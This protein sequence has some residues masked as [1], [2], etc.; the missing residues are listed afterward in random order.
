[1]KVRDATFYPSGEQMTPR[2]SDR[3]R[4]SPR[5]AAALATRVCNHPSA[6]EGLQSLSAEKRA[7]SAVEHTPVHTAAD[8]SSFA[9]T[10]A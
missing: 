5:K 2:E 7:S 8:E 10:R 3:R 6:S 4:C 1:M 9:V